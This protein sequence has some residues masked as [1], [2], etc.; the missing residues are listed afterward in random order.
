MSKRAAISAGG[1]WYP[2]A[3]SHSRAP[4]RCAAAPRSAGPADLGRQLVPGRLLAAQVA[5]RQLDQQG[6]HRL[7]DAGQVRRRQQPVRMA[8]GPAGQVMQP[9]VSLPLVP[10]Q[11]AHRV[12]YDSAP[13]AAVGVYPQHRLLRHRPAGQEHRGRLA[14][15]PGDLGLELGDHAAAA[16]PVRLG[17]RRDGG[18]QLGGRHPAV[19]GQED[20]TGCTQCSQVL[21]SQV[22][23]GEIIHGG[24]DDILP[25]WPAGPQAP[26]TA[27]PGPPGRH[28]WSAPRGQ[29]L[30][31]FP[32]QQRHRA[33]K[34]VVR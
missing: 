26:G 27:G 1:R 15:Q 7:G 5:L 6:R 2:A 16:V 24:H 17:V 33:P 12:E 18:Q 25:G 20:G 13:L 10:F 34:V 30:W 9:L 4:S 11:V 14:E 31:P 32:G 23:G 22:L 28:S 19:T 3:D 29:V 21:C 8:G